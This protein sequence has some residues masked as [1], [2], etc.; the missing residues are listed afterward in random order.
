MKRSIDEKNAHLLQSSS[1]ESFTLRAMHAI[2]VSGVHKRKYHILIHVRWGQHVCVFDEYL[3]T[4][5]FWEF[6]C[7][8]LV[9]YYHMKDS[10]C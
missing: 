10:F 5:Q 2:L 1:C 9:L 3:G 6:N 4:F 7:E 8:G